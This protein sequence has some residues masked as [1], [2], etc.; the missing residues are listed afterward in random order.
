M[1]T[2]LLLED[3]QDSVL[4]L[5]SHAGMRD[6]DVLG[7]LLGSLAL[8]FV[9]LLLITGTATAGMVGPVV[10][11]LSDSRFGDD[12]RILARSSLGAYIA[13][14]ASACLRQVSVADHMI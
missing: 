3:A 12:V 1:K 9:G 8:R 4:E 14:V 6:E 5:V 11:A 10:D 13:D 2:D 7:L